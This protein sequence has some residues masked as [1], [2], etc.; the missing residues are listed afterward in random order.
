[1]SAMNF[2]IRPATAADADAISQLVSGWAHHYL[3]DP[4]S[5]EASAFLA[6]LAPA[7]TAQRI[8]A[9]QF[10]HYLAQDDARVCGV[11]VMRDG[12]RIHHFFVHADAHGRGIGRALWEHAKA[13]SAASVFFVNSALPAI[14]VYERFGFV[15]AA[16]QQ[17][18]NGLVFVPM[19]TAPSS[20]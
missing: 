19:Q 15:V 17:S 9:P 18:A 8:A 4:T 5:Q 10:R 3:A 1:M 7:A 13:N 2:H 16:A 14:A 12:S 6:S 20:E 11:I